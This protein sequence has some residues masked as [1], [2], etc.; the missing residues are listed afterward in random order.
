MRVISEWR[1][2]CWCRT[3]I[4]RQVV[5]L[6]KIR[7]RHTALNNAGCWS[8]RLTACP[9]C[10]TMFAEAPSRRLQTRVQNCQ[11]I[12]AA[13]RRKTWNAAMNMCTSC[14]VFATFHR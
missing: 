5:R 12:I 2:V 11:T 9:E 7:R 13:S 8:P 4:P 3:A 6:C 14:K 10:T 1:L